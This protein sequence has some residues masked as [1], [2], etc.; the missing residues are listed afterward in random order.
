[1]AGQ[2]L[3]HHGLGYAA[4]TQASLAAATSVVTATALEALFLGVRL[5]THTLLGACLLIG[6]VALSVSR[7]V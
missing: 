2:V 4:A 1:M 6:A 5:S 3:L 7:R